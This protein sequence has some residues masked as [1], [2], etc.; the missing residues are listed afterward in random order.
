MTTQLLGYRKTDHFLYRQWDRS[1]HDQILYKILPYAECIDC[2]KDIIIAA[3]SFLKRKGVV[4]AKKQ[5][6]VIV[7]SRKRL[8]T[9]Y[10]TDH[11]DYLYSK[12][13]FAHIQNLK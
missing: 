9:S 4:L 5:S 10:W 13:P 7:I 2:R 8:M 3:P 6:L 12:E 11:P 1:I